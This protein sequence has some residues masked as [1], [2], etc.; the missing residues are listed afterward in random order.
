MRILIVGAGAVGCLVGGRLAQ[1]GAQVTLVGR[2][3]LVEAV[4]ARGLML[5]AGG[6]ATNLRNLTAVASL[7]E[8][9]QRYDLAVLSVKGYDTAA[10]IEELRT[11]MPAPP[12]LL[13][14]QNGVGN[15]EALAAAG[16][17]VV[18]GIVTTPVSM[19]APA[20]VTIHKTGSVVLAPWSDAVP[21]GLLARTADYLR[22]GGFPARMSDD[23][24]ALKWGK[25]LLNLI[26]NAACAILDWTPDRLYADG[27]SATMEIWAL[28]EAVQA[29]RG[30]AIPLRPLAGY[31]LPL[32]AWAVTRWPLPLLRG[33]FRRIVVAGRGNKMPS[34]Q[35]D[36]QRGKSHSEV[37]FLNGAVVRLGRRVG[38]ATPVNHLLTETLLGIAQGSV[39]WETYRHRADRLW[40][41]ATAR[42]AGR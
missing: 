27:R 32:L 41:E 23:A 11:A 40:H 29:M 17:R 26:G 21:D 8:A 3:P 25:L 39:P 4:K 20:V 30:A 14:L 24:R 19:A 12:P 2:P 9:G 6:K 16:H 10:V 22:A 18:A 15:E 7:S 5:I 38:V 13:S 37:A 34:L 31:P 36:L 42:R 35:M 28:Q 1:G 33:I